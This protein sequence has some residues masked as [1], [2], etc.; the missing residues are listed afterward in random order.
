MRP[1]ERFFRTS[2]LKHFSESRFKSCLVILTDWQDCRYSRRR[3]LK[4]TV[5]IGQ[6]RRNRDDCRGRKFTLHPGAVYQKFTTAL[7]AVFRVFKY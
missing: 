3:L 2:A 4:L 7:A 5:Q 6:T 1:E